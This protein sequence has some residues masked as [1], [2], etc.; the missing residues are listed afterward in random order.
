MRKQRQDALGWW[1]GTSREK[2]ARHVPRSFDHNSFEL[3]GNRKTK[4]RGLACANKDKMPS[5]GGTERLEE[6]LQD[7]FLAV[8]ITIPLCYLE[9]EK[10][11]ISANSA[12]TSYI[13]LRA[14]LQL[15]V[16]K[17]SN[18]S[19][20]V[21]SYRN[22][23][24]FISHSHPSAIW[25]RK[26]SLFLFQI[27]PRCFFFSSSQAKILRYHETNRD[28]K[29]WSVCSIPYSGTSTEIER[30]PQLCRK[31]ENTYR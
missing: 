15:M 8:L 6:G 7:M 4:S 19:V 18:R 17:H 1:H 14:S 10:R 26:C 22:E 13:K 21:N 16:T 9:I 2:V 12:S 20:L 30:N 25:K 11:N 3:L 29:R 24:C 23:I 27:L 28:S 31:T 5:V